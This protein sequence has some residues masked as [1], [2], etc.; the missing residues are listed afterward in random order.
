MSLLYSVPIPDAPITRL[1][2]TVLPATDTTPS[3]SMN[4]KNKS[5][6]HQY[7]N[8]YFVRLRHLRTPIEKEALRRWKDVA[9]SPK[10]VPR[11]LDVLKGQ[12][13][14]I[15]GTVY[16]EMPLKPNVLEDIGRDHSIPAPPPLDKI[17]SPNDSIMLEDESGRIQLVGDRLKNT[18]LVTGVIA[19]ALGV[20]TISGEFEVVDICFPG[21]APQEESG[22]DDVEENESVDQGQEEYVAFISGLD[23]GSQSPS[24]AQTQMLAEYLSGEAG[25]IDDQISASQITRL[26]ILGNSL[27][28]I[29]GAGTEVE[30]EKGKKSCRYGYD[31]TSFSPH[32]TINLSAHLHD[33]ARSIPIHLLPGASDP[34]GTILP[35]QSFPR[36]MFGKASR[37]SSFSCET[38][39]TY[40]RL[41]PGPPDEPI[42]KGKGKS[43]SSLKLASTSGSA[44][45]KRRPRTVLATSGQP[46]SD[47]F[48]YL[49]SPPATRLNLAEATLR[50][51]HMAPTA[52]DTL[53]CHP[54]FHSDPFILAQTPDI[55]AIGCQPNF[56][57]RLV[58]EGKRRCRIVLI[59]SFSE[60]GV[61]VLVSLK[62]L[63]VRLV[64]FAA[65]S[66]GNAMVEV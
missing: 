14:Y 27:A 25:G 45:P 7:A 37:Y 47:M 41:S 53:W 12:L 49:P 32:P 62:T 38:N 21:M 16:M 40:V 54:F 64:R 65:E 48:K 4:A 22:D 55:Y 29:A 20:E 33:I 35:Q 34:S 42:S 30:P 59:P 6:K 39:P 57:S 9:G 24:E 60:S 17:H 46:L 43:T 3:F 44:K 51:R 8:I 61:L 26:M 50:W 19:G 15:V 36:A 56:S 52:P 11:V 18:Q 58:R 28:P 2:S 23:I 13:C 10:L 31:N 66:R 63:D 5:F 1:R